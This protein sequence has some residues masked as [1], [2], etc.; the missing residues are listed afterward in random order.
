[1]SKTAFSLVVILLFSLVS[2]HAQVSN[3]CLPSSGGNASS[4]IGQ[5]DF[6]SASS[7]SGLNTLNQPTD[8]AIDGNTGK[9]YVTDSTTNQ[10]ILRFSSSNALVTNA[11][12]DLV[13]Y[14][15]GSTGCTSF[16][17][18][19]PGQLAYL[20]TDLY[21][22]DIVNSRVLKLAN[23]PT[24]NATIT[25]ST[26]VFGHP[27]NSDCT[28]AGT[29]KDF[30][31]PN[32]VAIT[33]NGSLFVSDSSTSCVIK[34]FDGANNA[35]NYPTPNVVLG[36]G[37]CGVVSQNTLSTQVQYLSVDKTNGHLFASDAGYNRV[38][39]FK[40]AHLK[41]NA[42]GADTVFGQPNFTSSAAACGVASFQYP[43]G[44]QYNAQ[45]NVLIVVDE[46]NARVIFIDTP[47]SAANGTN[48]STT[49]I[50]QANT[51]TCVPGSTNVTTLNNPY[52]VSY[53]SDFPGVFLLVSDYNAH[54]V[55]RYQ[56]TN[57]TFSRSVSFSQTIAASVNASSVAP[58][59]VAGSIN[60]SS[61][62][63][64]S[65]SGVVVNASS[66]GVAVNASSSG[67][68]VNA[69]SS[70]VAVN[71]SSSGVAVNASSS[72]VAV[73]ASS[74]GVAVNASSS[75]V[76]ASSSG[77]V[78]ASSSGG[79]PS[80][81]A[82]SSVSQSNTPSET[83]PQN[84]PSVTPIVPPQIPSSGV[85][86]AP[87]VCG[88]GIVEA[89]E[90]CD[91]GA[92]VPRT[93]CCTSFCTNL[94]VRSVCG[95]ATSKCTKRPKCGRSPTSRQLV[96]NPGVAKPVGTHC[97]RGGLFSRKTCKADGTCSK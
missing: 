25:N 95:K 56:C 90:E 22:V 19:N 36:N 92:A 84:T 87:L 20:G 35:S 53:S 71:A 10:R 17:I 70:G 58:S 82:T 23:A 68:A 46:Q 96:C 52:G 54:R 66:S 5:T 73:N 74:S 97:G 64:A 26:T 3:M 42:S 94:P 85:S 48:F 93:K 21:V 81:T 27:N 15:N 61:V 88:N 11:S 14:G 32:G 2:I 57:T 37:T 8:V 67:V 40:Q 4:V 62:V 6:V 76:A 80:L 59:T 34:R 12:A 43:Y 77:A 89:G 63:V 60:A 91:A 1:M 55:T 9:V 38:L 86:V 65:S 16:G 18:F 24:V 7:G 30:T 31:N 47:L 50:G 79:V 78:A 28:S 29:V 75:G 51:S 83:N 13:L 45:D 69:S 41:T 39:L 44:I 72:G 49:V 33:N